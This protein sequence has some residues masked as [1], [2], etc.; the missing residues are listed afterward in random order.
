VKFKQ[1]KYEWTVPKIE[2]L[3]EIR[4]KNGGGK[5]RDTKYKDFCRYEL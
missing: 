4:R 2:I 1:F 3:K 5:E